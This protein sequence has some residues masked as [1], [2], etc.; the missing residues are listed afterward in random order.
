MSG[1]TSGARS[2]SIWVWV[3]IAS[4]AVVYLVVSSIGGTQ[5]PYLTASELS[6]SAGQHVRV[7][8][9]VAVGGI[10]S[11]GAGDVSIQFKLID[12]SGDTV[13]VR[14]T[15]VRPDA[16][17]EGAQA[18]AEG[19][20]DPAGRVFTAVLLQAKCPSKYEAAVPVNK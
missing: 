20:Y 1:E 6:A 12:E 2:K 10:E 16:F 9:K 19:T 3:V 13:L 15:G 5:L 4:A 8:G 17:R 14:Y 18:V 7:A 11:D